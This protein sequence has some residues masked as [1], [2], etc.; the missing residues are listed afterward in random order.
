MHRTP[1][2]QPELVFVLP[3]VLRYGG[4]CRERIAVDAECLDEAVAGQV[5]DTVGRGQ[6]QRRPPMLPG[7]AGVGIVVQDLI[8][9]AE[10]ESVQEV[11]HREPSLTSADH[12]DVAVGVDQWVRRGSRV[13][14]TAHF[15]TSGSVGFRV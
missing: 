3:E 9:V 13:V 1:N 11:R 14:H 6:G 15:S 7:P 2:T 8:A 5:V 4:A 12:Q 10:A